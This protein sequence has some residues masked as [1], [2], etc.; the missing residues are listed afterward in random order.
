[1]YSEIFIGTI[2]HN[3]K[4]KILKMFWRNFAV[5]YICEEIRRN[6]LFKKTKSCIFLFYI[7]KKFFDLACK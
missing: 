2:R 1:M 6:F 5:K 4:T 3:Q 7:K